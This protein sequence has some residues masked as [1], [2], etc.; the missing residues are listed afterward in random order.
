MIDSSFLAERTHVHANFTFTEPEKY[1]G[2]AH[3]LVVIFAAWFFLRLLS[4][5]CGICQL[6][7][8]SE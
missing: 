3:N 7:L 5:P 6:G 2:K 8:G 4:L 1:L